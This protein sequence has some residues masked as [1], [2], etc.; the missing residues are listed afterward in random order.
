MT[1]DDRQA[2]I[3]WYDRNRTRTAELFGLLS[4]EAYYS[5]PIGL[6]N[7]IVFYEGHLPGFSF[8]TLVKRGLG[9]PSID[10]RLEDLFARG[11]DPH[12]SVSD[13]K[14]RGNEAD[15]WPSR[16]AVK[17]FCD[18][19]DR[20]VREALASGDI[21]QA[22]HPLL[23][24]AEAAFSIIEHEATHLET[25][26]Y[27]WHRL[28]LDQ[29]TRPNGYQP[30]IG[31][32][33]PDQAWVEVPPGRA[34]LGVDRTEVPFAWDNECP[35]YS[36]DVPA[37][38][39]QRHNV[40]NAAFAEFVAAGGYGESRWWRPEDWEWVQQ[41]GRTHPIFWERDGA[42]WLWRGMFDRLPLPEWWPVFVSQ[43]EASAYAR[44][45]GLRLPT[46]AEYQRAACGSPDGRPRR[47]P[48]GSDAPDDTRGAFDFHSWDPQ[49]AGRHPAG[50]S[51]WGVHD[52]VGNGWEWTGT[53]FGP[54]PGFTVLPSYPE[55]SAEFFDGEHFVMKGASPVTARELLRPSF[56][57]WF[58]SRYPYMYATFRCVK[59]SGAGA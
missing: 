45:K 58:R 11:I 49:P 26:M 29:K 1:T 16:E 14:A 21:E 31:G 47:H 30:V 13:A 52:L 39:I 27:M 15:L 53:E 44:W 8:N 56:R 5:R 48:W 22:G 6:R 41:E 32:T 36:E 18:E 54:F 28:P 46:E 24:R 50:Q 17:Q 40:T 4:D 51:A 12:E 38:A 10:A 19:A 57:N 43:A 59:A 9:Q 55:Y 35:A 2:L 20:Q 33:P 34:V 3:D 37:F 23:D 42:R 25:L 7:P